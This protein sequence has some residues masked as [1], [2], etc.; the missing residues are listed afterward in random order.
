MANENNTICKSVFKNGTS[1]TS[2][3]QFT[4]KWIELINF[5]EKNKKGIV[6]PAS[7]GIL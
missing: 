7:K 1:Y 4:N 6:Y 5:S 2:T 3:A